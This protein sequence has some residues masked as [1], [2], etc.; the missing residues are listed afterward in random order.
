VSK[1]NSK[2]KKINLE[3]LN[4]DEIIKELVASCLLGRTLASFGAILTKR[5]DKDSDLMYNLLRANRNY[6]ERLPVKAEVSKVTRDNVKKYTLS[7]AIEWYK[8]EYP[9][10]SQPLVKKL[11]ERTSDSKPAIKYGLR[12]G[13]DLPDEYYINLLA[14]ILPLDK[15]QAR[16]LYLTIIKPSL[17]EQRDEGELVTKTMKE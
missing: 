2:R 3:E 14:T 17:K 1:K 6:S 11:E 16:S 8:E 4:P 13:K 9:R 7:Q 5:E 12:D 15:R 10:E